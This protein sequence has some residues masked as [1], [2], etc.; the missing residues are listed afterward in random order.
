MKETLIFGINRFAELLSEYMEEDGIS[1]AGFL[2][3]EKYKP[4]TDLFCRKPIF[5]TEYMEQEVPAEQYN[6]ILALGY[7]KMNTIR[8]KKY[9]EMKEKG[10][11]IIG[12]R[13]STALI[14]TDQIGEGNIFLENVTIGKHVKIGTG[15]IFYLCAHLAH[16]TQVKDFN[17]FA[18]SCSVAGSVSIYN[19]CFFGNNCTLKNGIQVHDYT[20]VGAG[21][22]LQRNT[23]I[24]GV[25]VPARC[26]QLEGKNSLDIFNLE[27]KIY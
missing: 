27:E 19:N 7:H 1:V 22:Y 3:D 6:V 10:Y 4:D 8:Q 20:L 21:C 18:I 9:Q 13:H 2:V 26:V 5:Y 24:G 14:Q 23:D 11:E 16:H 15:N 17:F 12:Y 25:F